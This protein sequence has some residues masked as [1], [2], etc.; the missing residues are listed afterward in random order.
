MV[1]ISVIIPIYN[2]E[3]YLGQC[4]D[5]VVNQSF[6]DIEII[7]VNDGS[8]D[9]SL[10]ILN[11]YE[12]KDSR[13]RIYS[14]K[15]QGAGA[16]RN[17]ALEYASGEYVYFMDADDYLDLNALEELYDI[18]A[19]KNADFVI[20]KINNFYENPNA[21]ID[22]D[23]EYYS[24]PYLKEKVGEETFSYDDVSKIALELCVCPPGNFFKHEFLKDIRFP[25]GLLYEDNVFFA[26]A[27][28]KANTIYFYDKFLYNRRRRE[29]STTAPISV[30][31]MDIIDITD[32][33]IDLCVEYNHEHHKRKLY[34]RIFNDIY[35]IFKNADSSTKEEL[36]KK[37]KHDYLKHKDKWEQDKFFI[38]KLNPRYKHMFNCAIKSKNARKFESC[39]DGY[40]KES[41]FKKLRKKL[42]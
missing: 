20:F 32:I 12:N 21:T 13:I 35:T 23:Y 7:C 16:T 41:I 11:E 3:E 24:M 2:V 14:Q 39:V 37:I 26:N 42:L 6:K 22:F 40:S 34:Y 29:S 17:N 5:S 1:K 33:L 28:F 10:N 30:K 25:E 36:F 4:L 15:N 8:T 19:E 31:T 9:N 27:I 18:A 38:N